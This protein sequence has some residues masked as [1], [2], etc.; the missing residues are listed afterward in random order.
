MDEPE[1]RLG[2]SER[3]QDI[4]NLLNNNKY[5]KRYKNIL[6]TLGVDGLIYKF[7]KKIKSI[8]T[9]PAL[10]TKVIDTLGAGDA[11]FSYTSAFIKNTND[12]RIIAIIGSVA[13]AIKTNILGHS[14]YVSI[15][16]ITKSLRTILK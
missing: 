5:L 1:V 14:S 10:N 13:G 16:E 4:T 12:P 8:I 2:L 6:I 15:S 3:Y 7:G 11:V 9:F